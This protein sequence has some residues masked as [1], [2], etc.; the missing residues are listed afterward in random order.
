MPLRDRAR[1]TLAV[2]LS[3]ALLS[4]PRSGI[5]LHF[6]NMTPA[7]IWRAGTNCVVHACLVA[8]AMLKPWVQRG[9]WTKGGGVRRRFG[10][11]EWPQ[12]Q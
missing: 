6:C 9:I 5:A 11:C 7:A 1:W 3:M 2:L 4:A 10:V 8:L 12:Q